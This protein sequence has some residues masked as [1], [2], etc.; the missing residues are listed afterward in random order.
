MY[1]KEELESMNIPEL[2]GIAEQLGV[3]VSPDDELESVVYAILDKA[4]E[5]S[6][7]NVAT[8]SPKRK[9]TRIVKKDTNKV[10]T[11]NGKE[12]E[13]F[14]LKNRQGKTADTK[15]TPLFGDL[16][17]SMTEGEPTMQEQA[18]AEEPTEALPKA[19]AKR[20]R[21][22]KAKPETE[23]GPEQTHENTTED[24]VQ[25][26]DA[27]NQETTDYN[28]ESMID[29]VPEAGFT[30][31]NINEDLQADKDLLEQLQ[32]K[33][34]LHN[35][36]SEST[37]TSNM[38]GVWEGDPETE[39]TSSLSWICPSRIKEPCPHLTYS[40]GPRYTI[41]R[42]IFSIRNSRQAT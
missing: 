33:L 4:A 13:N 10:Y 38:N 32:E 27:D 25:E 29:I 1:T 12:G 42:W 26:T 36:E 39:L 14:D 6:A 5:D 21:K 3:K 8:T 16:P 9:R 30:P 2:M 24:G 18:P 37:K 20:G 28:T 7:A 34:T 11:V 35:Q 41:R 23:T 15:A 31:D 40:I 17:D 22:P 19:P